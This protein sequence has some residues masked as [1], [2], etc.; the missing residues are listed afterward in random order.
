MNSS[1]PQPSRVAPAKP[2]IVNGMP[3]GLSGILLRT[4]PLV[5]GSSP[6][7]QAMTCWSGPTWK[8]PMIIL[9]EEREKIEVKTNSWVESFIFE[10]FLVPVCSGR[11]RNKFQIN[12]G[13]DG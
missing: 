1:P 4:A 10:F 9:A 3:H 12:G 11:R 5:H 7:F 13:N 6:S 8:L 2:V